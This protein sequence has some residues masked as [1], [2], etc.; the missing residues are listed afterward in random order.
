MSQEGYVGIFKS[1]GLLKVLTQAIA[2]WDVEASNIDLFDDS[3]VLSKLIGR[4]TTSLSD[5]VKKTLA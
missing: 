4:L 2:S 1:L 3:K 5:A